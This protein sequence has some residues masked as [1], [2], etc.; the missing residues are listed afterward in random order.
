MNTWHLLLTKPLFPWSTRKIGDSY[1][2]C[3]FNKQ[4]TFN[5][6]R[7]EFQH[8]RNVPD[9]NCWPSHLTHNYFHFP[10]PHRTHE[11][12]PMLHSWRR[13]IRRTWSV[14]QRTPAT[15][16]MTD[17]KTRSLQLIPRLGSF[18][19]QRISPHW[20]WSAQQRGCWC[21]RE[22]VNLFFFFVG[23]RFLQRCV[24]LLLAWLTYYQT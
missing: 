1:N 18:Q 5:A 12:L 10:L 7:F 24:V 20:R 6:K 9:Q 15:E 11:F 3:R 17:K 8:K 19:R 13:L 2:S 16:M 23:F 4:F 21:T 14:F 22:S